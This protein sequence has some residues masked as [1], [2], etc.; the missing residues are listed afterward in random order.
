MPRSGCTSR[1]G[2]PRCRWWSPP[3]WW[4]SASERWGRGN[5]CRSGAAMENRVLAKHLI[6][7]IRENLTPAQTT[8]SQRHYLLLGCCIGSHY[9]HIWYY[10][11]PLKHPR[12]F[13]NPVPQGPLQIQTAG[14]AS[15]SEPPD[16][17][18]C[19]WRSTWC[20]PLVC[21]SKN[22]PQVADLKEA[23]PTTRG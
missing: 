19:Q 23:W 22:N 18:M 21:T 20:Q 13:F 7:L 10:A 9:R 11:Q 16:P 12:T 6:L 5:S 14:T 2:A 3:L 17:P 4:R 1:R 8:A 15:H